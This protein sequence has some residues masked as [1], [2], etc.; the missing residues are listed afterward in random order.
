MNIALAE[1]IVKHK[2]PWEMTLPELELVEKAVRYALWEQYDRDKRASIDLRK[3]DM[4]RWCLVVLKS[5]ST[6]AV[7]K[8]KLKKKYLLEVKYYLE[9]KKTDIPLIIRK[10]LEL[11]GDV[12]FFLFTHRVLTGSL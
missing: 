9:N 5:P 3:K 2:E 8:H 11:L 6:D 7:L 12:Q 10:H 1:K 4:G